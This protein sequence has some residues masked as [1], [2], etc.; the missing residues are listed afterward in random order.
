MGPKGFIWT[1]FPQP[2]HGPSQTYVGSF[3][4]AMGSIRPGVGPLK[5]GNVGYDSSG[6]VLWTRAE[7]SAR[8]SGL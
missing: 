5:S 1:L 3:W 8:E 2:W 6:F 7:G 4:P